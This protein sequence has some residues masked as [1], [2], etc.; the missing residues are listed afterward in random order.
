[1][2]AGIV[3]IGSASEPFN[4]TVE[5]RLHGN[6]T[7]PSEFVFSPNIQVGN[8][9]FIITGTV[10]M[11]GNPRSSST[12]LVANAYKGQDNLYVATDL[13]WKEGDI[14]GLTPTNMDAKGYETVTIK[15]YTAGTGHVFIEGNLTS[16]HFGAVKSTAED[17]SGVDMRGEVMLLTRDIMITAS[18]DTNSTTK[19]HPEPWPCRVLVADFFE[20]SD[21]KY[22]KGTIHMDNV[23]IYNCSQ[24]DTLNPALKFENA[25][26]GTKVFKNGVIASGRAEGVH[27]SRS[28]R[29][30]M[31]NNVIH[32][33][34]LYGVKAEG[35]ANLVLENN[36]LNGV[37][38]T[39]QRN[40]PNLKW[41]TPMGG[42]DLA[43]A[44]AMTVK[45]NTASGIWHS[46]FRMPA[47]ACDDANPT[48]KIEDNVAHSNS[49]FGVIVSSGAGRCSEF[50]KF[51]GYK[52]QLAT[53]HMGGAVGSHNVAK[54]NVVIDSAYGLA[55]FADSGG[56]VHVKENIIY[57]SK[58][59]KNSDCPYSENGKCGCGSRIGVIA[60][61]FGGNPTEMKNELKIKKMFS[62]GGGWGGTSM[63][64]L[65]KFIGFDS[66]TNAC[67]GTQA[68]I[69][70]NKKHSDYHPIA[71]F[72]NNKFIDTDESALFKLDTPPQGWANGADCG[73]FT[74]TGLYNLLIKVENSIFSGVPSVFGLPKKF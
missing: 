25:I 19:A 37:R 11:H 50:S 3:D 26:Q 48:N 16:Y 64:E 35:A 68:A 15:N 4:S 57:G 71:N 27:I 5:I 41:P 2:R 7:S 65:N 49:G 52:N 66:K 56:H 34:V 67:G 40:P 17:Y 55:V 22:R 8:K 13:D 74:C 1:V 42:W 29:V 73:P 47:K 45:N 14:L 53:I 54:D 18:T 39:L 23:S 9:N 60:P 6:N 51:Y 44:N 61:T 63:F 36:I 20:P 32:D 72:R 43:A 62:Q 70:S 59:M 33:F 28:Q 69:G 46:G 12:R 10:N 21:F 38:P 24:T 58:N 31:T 30:T